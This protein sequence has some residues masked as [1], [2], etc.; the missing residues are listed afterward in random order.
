MIPCSSVWDN[1]CFALS[2]KTLKDIKWQPNYTKVS[3]DFTAQNYTAVSP[4]PQESSKGYSYG[5]S[6]FG[7]GELDKKAKHK[8]GLSDAKPTTFLLLLPLHSCSITGKTVSCVVF[9]P[10]CLCS[11]C[12]AAPLHLHHHHPSSS[13]FPYLTFQMFHSQK[14]WWI[15]KS[16]QEYWRP[17][18]F[19][20]RNYKTLLFSIC[21]W[22]FWA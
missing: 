10:N 22:L 15:S 12:S 5:T 7:L 19:K 14:K 20:A 16:F 3:L 18:P 8:V 6:R 9:S 17:M 13:I 2:P 1:W 11:Y 4:Y 21:T